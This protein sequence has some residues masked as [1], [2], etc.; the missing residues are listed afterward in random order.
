MREMN[1]AT[2]ETVTTT[3]DAAEMDE[4]LWHVLWQS[5][6][7][8]RDVRRAFSV[9]GE[10]LE[11]VVKENGRIVGGLVAVWTAETEVELRHLAVAYNAQRHGNGRSLVAELVGIVGLRGCRRIHTI[12][13]NTSADFFRQLGFRPTSGKTH[14]H[15][16]FAKH[17]IR[18]ELMEKTIE[19]VD[20]G[21][22]IQ[23][24]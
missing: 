18:F 13:R 6:G 7:L 12:A 9:G 20:A 14:E 5:L 11:L 10:E 4:L 1:K 16:A 21:D 15:P 24:T 17:G 3:T 23:R 8:P 2:V 19:P 22:A